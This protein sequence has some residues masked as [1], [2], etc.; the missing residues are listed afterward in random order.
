ME[1]EENFHKK[2]LHFMNALRIAE[3][4]DRGSLAT[5]VNVCT[6]TS[7]L[8]TRQYLTTGRKGEST[9]RVAR[10]CYSLLCLP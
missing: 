3:R 10:Y 1:E 9:D 7:S 8:I 4:D 2:V 6:D 5:F